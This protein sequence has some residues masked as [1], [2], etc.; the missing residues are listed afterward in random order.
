MI[1]TSYKQNKISHF[2]NHLLEGRIENVKTLFLTSLFIIVVIGLVC[3]IMGITSFCNLDKIKDEKL[4][5]IKKTNSTR[6]VIL[7]AIYVVIV[8]PA[9]LFF[10]SD[11]YGVFQYLWFLAFL[12]FPIAVF[13]MVISLVFFIRVGISSIQTGTKL[14]KEGINDIESIVFGIIVLVF[15]FIVVLAI[16]GAIAY[17]LGAVTAGLF[18]NNG[19]NDHSELLFAR[20]IKGCLFSVIYK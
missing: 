3:L 10:M 2:L 14:K 16:L 12:F 8:A 17:S 4:K 7:G 6:I 1:E 5:K 15:G 20:T 13:L 11:P 19:A 9:A 18:K